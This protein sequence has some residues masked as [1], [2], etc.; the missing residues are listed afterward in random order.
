LIFLIVLKIKHEIWKLLF[1]VMYFR[2]FFAFIT[3]LLIFHD[4]LNIFIVFL[5]LSILERKGERRIY[6]FNNHKE[7]LIRT[8]SNLIELIVNTKK[9]VDIINLNLPLAM[10]SLLLNY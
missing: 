5:D 4:H 10:F 8:N 1:L 9:I 7:A 6:R 3:K 2:D